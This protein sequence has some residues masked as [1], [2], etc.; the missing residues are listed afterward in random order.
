MLVFYVHE[1]VSSNYHSSNSTSAMVEAGSRHLWPM[2]GL[3]RLT[4]RTGTVRT[5]MTSGNFTDGTSSSLANV[6]VSSRFTTRTGTVRMNMPKR[7]PTDGTYY[8]S[9]LSSSQWITLVSE[10]RIYDPSDG[11]WATMELHGGQNLRTVSL[12]NQVP[13]YPTLTVTETL[14]EYRIAEDK[15]R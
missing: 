13:P 6:T 8:S 12:N 15:R 1:F 9:S 11:K 3:A 2:C 7:N 10:V 5:N 4:A 14:R